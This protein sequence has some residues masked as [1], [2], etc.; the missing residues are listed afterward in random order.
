VSTEQKRLE[1]DAAKVRKQW[2]LMTEK[3]YE[4]EGEN[5]GDSKE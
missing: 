3:A 5:K 1:R 2:M 4:G